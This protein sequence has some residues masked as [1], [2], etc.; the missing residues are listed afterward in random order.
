VGQ[1]LRWPAGGELTATGGESPHPRKGQTN[2]TKSPGLF[3][4]EQG[5]GVPKRLRRCNFKMHKALW[6][7]FG[8][9]FV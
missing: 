5:S 2:K 9:L 7:F 8:T 6:R 3:S 1:G 4:R